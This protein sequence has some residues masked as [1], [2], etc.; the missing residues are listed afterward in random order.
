MAADLFEYLKQTQR[1]LRD[2]NQELINPADMMDFIN[3]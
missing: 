1:L 3:R 2:G